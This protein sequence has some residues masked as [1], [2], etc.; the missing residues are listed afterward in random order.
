MPEHGQR[1]M[2]LGTELG[3]TRR[4]LLRRGAIVGGTLLWAAPAVQSIT[5]PAFAATTAGSARYYCC[6]C[7]RVDQKPGGAPCSCAANGAPPL[8]PNNDADCQA[9]CRSQ[10]YSNHDFDSG[11][12][13]CSCSSSSCTPCSCN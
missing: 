11:L 4:D 12:N 7:F 8:V 10:G 5:K 1:R 3:L 2:D 13:S 6:Y 9:L